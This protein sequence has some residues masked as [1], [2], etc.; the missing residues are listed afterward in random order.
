MPRLRAL[1]PGEATGKA[2]E[3]LEQV[4]STLGMTPNFPSCHGP[5]A[6]PARGVPRLQ[7][8]A[9]SRRTTRYIARANRSDR[10]R[11]STGAPTAWLPHTAVGKM[12]GLS[13]EDTLDSRRGVS[14]SSKIEAA[15]QFSRKLVKTRGRVVDEDVIRIRRAGYGDAEIAEMVANVALNT[16]DNYFN[17]VAETV[18]DFPKVPA[19]S[20]P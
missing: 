20:S 6:G 17:L 14:P 10:R 7:Q 4:Q 13:E 2:K 19:L 16:F 18:V 3:L 15:L 11:D 1:D 12:V 9:W 5:F 8:C